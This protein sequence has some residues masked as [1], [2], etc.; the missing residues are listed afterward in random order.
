MP[1]SHKEAN[2]GIDLYLAVLD[3]FSKY[4]RVKPLKNKTSDAVAKT[5]KEIF[6][7]SRRKPRELW[8][9]RGGEFTGLIDKTPDKPPGPFDCPHCGKENKNHSGLTQ[10][11]NKYCPVLL[12]GIAKENKTKLKGIT[13]YHTEGKNKA[14]VA[15]RFVKTIKGMIWKYMTNNDIKKVIDVLPDKVNEYNNTKHSTIRMTPVEASKKEN[16]E[17]VF[18][19]AYKEKDKPIKEIEAEIS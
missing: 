7:E 3:V 19:T 9:D 16:Q 6:S 13:L 14:S 12:P 8:T 18:K 4:G 5:F 2:D 15:E 11:L 1:Q 17:K 10:H